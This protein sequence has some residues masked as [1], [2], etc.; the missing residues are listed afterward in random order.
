MDDLISDIG[1][2]ARHSFEDQ[3]TPIEEAKQLYGQHIAVLGG[4]DMDLLARGSEEEVRIRVRQVAS[5][6]APGGGFALGTGNSAA[7][8]IRPENFLAMLD[9]GRKFTA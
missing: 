2:D 8:Y 3:V 7:N 9:E 5:A 6:C 4:I 1:I